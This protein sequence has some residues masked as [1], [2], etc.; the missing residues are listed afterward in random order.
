MFV[1]M[2]LGTG[3]LSR[4]LP[5]VDARR[6]ERGGTADPFKNRKGSGTL[7]KVSLD[8]FNLVAMFV[9]IGLG[10]RAPRRALPHVD[11]RRKE[12]GGTADP[13]KNRKGSGTLVTVSLDWV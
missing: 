7:V 9:P 4:A 5:G 11:V 13:F 1:P 2:G 10:T 12:R 3:A 8:W 6:K